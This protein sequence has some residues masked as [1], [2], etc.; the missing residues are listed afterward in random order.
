MARCTSRSRTTGWCDDVAPGGTG[1]AGGPAT[2]LPGHDCKVPSA[3]RPP[4]GAPAPQPGSA[5][6]AGVRVDGRGGATRRRGVLRTR[7]CGTELSQRRHDTALPQVA[8]PGPGH[9]QAGAD[10]TRAGRA[11][12]RSAARTVRAEGRASGA[13]DSGQ[14][15]GLGAGAAVKKAPVR[16]SRTS[17]SRERSVKAALLLHRAPPDGSLLPRARGTRG[18]AEVR[19]RRAAGAASPDMPPHHDDGPRSSGVA[20]GSSRRSAG[21]RGPAAGRLLQPAR[22]RRTGEAPPSAVSTLTTPSA[23]SRAACR[24]G[25]SG[26]R[27]ADVA[28]PHPHP[29]PLGRIPSAEIP[30]RAIAENFCA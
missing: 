4:V 3:H 8:A 13:G 10:G 30:R 23:R 12:I 14:L 22:G 19:G 27:R 17:T 20:S 21:R 18:R 15:R 1:C 11:P 28:G 9:L 6:V 26:P 24:T 16:P 5:S 25:C 29:S 7:R 2:R